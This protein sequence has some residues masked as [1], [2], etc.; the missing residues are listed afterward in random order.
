MAHNEV[1]HAELTCKSME[2]GH[3]FTLRLYKSERQAWLYDAEGN[4]WNPRSR[5]DVQDS[6]RPLRQERPEEQRIQKEPSPDLRSRPERREVMRP[7]PQDQQ[8]GVAPEG[9]ALHRCHGSAQKGREGLEEVLEG[10]G[11]R[12]GHAVTGTAP[13]PAPASRLLLRARAG[14]GG[15][16]TALHVE[17]LGDLEHVGKRPIEDQPRRQIE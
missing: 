8:V 17:L 15:R 13:R 16:Y 7:V 5:S 4:A 9:V 3:R 11:R 14:L 12:A 10:V 2:E 6:K 1:R